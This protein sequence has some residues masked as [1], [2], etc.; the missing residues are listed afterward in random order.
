MLLE[1]NCKQ[2]LK[3]IKEK[4][5]F[6]VFLKIL[7][8]G[9]LEKGRPKNLFYHVISFLIHF[10]SFRLILHKIGKGPKASCTFLRAYWERQRFE[11][12]RTSVSISALSLIA[13]CF[14]LWNEGK[15]RDTQTDQ[16]SLRL[17][18]R[19]CSL[20][21]LSHIPTFH[22]H[23]CSDAAAYLTAFPR[24]LKGNLNTTHPKSNSW[25]PPTWSSF[26]LPYLTE[27]LHYLPSCANQKPGSPV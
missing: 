23:H 22:S 1:I 11:V 3:P 24:C 16:R 25:F 19:P 9:H 20:D 18:P 4:Y 26:C 13:F 2:I 12:R 14:H 17:S 10:D 5:G 21:E 7:L 15:N 8:T 27:G 6:L